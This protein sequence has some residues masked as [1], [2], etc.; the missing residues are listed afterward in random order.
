MKFIGI[1]WK[2]LLLKLLK[3]NSDTDG[4][5]LLDEADIYFQQDESPHHWVLS[6][7]RQVDIIPDL[8]RLLDNVF[9][10]KW[11]GRGEPIEWPARSLDLMPF[12]FCMGSFVVYNPPLNLKKNFVKELLETAVMLLKMCAASS[13]NEPLLHR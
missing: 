12:F 5:S 2:C 4:N 10:D 8:S 9:I 3:I 6:H 11:T 7:V 1:C 13:N